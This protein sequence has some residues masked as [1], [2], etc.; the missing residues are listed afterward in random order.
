MFKWEGVCIRPVE[1]A[2]LVKLFE[3][4][5]DPRVRLKL[6]SIEMGGMEDQMKWF[7]EM[8]NDPSS[9]YYVYFSDEIDFIGIVRMD[10]IDWINRGIRVG[11]DI[12]PEFQG[13]G[14]GSQMF[15]LIKKYCFHYLGMHRIW[16]L[17]LATNDVAYKL[18]RCTGFNEE[19]RQ[20][21]AIYRD[22]QFLDYIMMSMLSTSFLD[23]SKSL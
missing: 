6:G 11:G 4:R 9:R 13:R 16:L 17:V 20:R 10:E 23:K 5:A 22:G 21:E 7:E 12:L 14:Y 15:E 1:K 2:D 3:L 18:Y 8:S 19:G